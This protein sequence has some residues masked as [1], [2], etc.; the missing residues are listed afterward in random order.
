MT[1]KARIKHKNIQ[2]R[3]I[4]GW[5]CV[6]EPNTKFDPDGPGEFQCD[7]IVDEAT[8]N[9]VKEQLK[10][11]Y[12]KELRAVMEQYP[13]KKITQRGLPI[14][15]KDGKFVL[16]TKKKGAY[17]DKKGVIRP[18]SVAIFDS[19]CN[20]I[21]DTS[22]LKLWGGSDIVLT[23][24]PNFWYVPA[25]GFG[26]T[27]VILAVQIVKLSDGGISSSSAERFGLTPIE[28]GYVNGGEN[29][30]S[31]FDAEEETT[32]TLTANF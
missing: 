14:E 4:T 28:E 2:T 10:E 5:C 9:Q 1:V 26:V 27:L 20:P 19:Q 15:Q 16:K 21:E 12:E 23:Y 8:V 13:D 11:P 3:G 31:A 22:D 24:R 29:L 18:A 6:V 30:D 25:L 17:K 32:E 7:L